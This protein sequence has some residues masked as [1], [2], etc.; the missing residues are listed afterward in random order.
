MLNA[1]VVRKDRGQVLVVFALVLPILIL[2]AG[3]AIDAGVLYVTKAKLSAAVDAAT[4]TG[5]K[6][7]TQGQATASTLALDMFDANYGANPPTPTITFPTDQYGDQQVEV[8][9]TANVNTYFMRYLPQWK[10]VAVGDTAIATR[11]KLDMAIVLDRSGS[12]CGG[13]VSCTYNGSDFGPGDDGWEALQ[14][15]VPQFV[16]LFDN[17]SDEVSL[18]SFSSNAVI[19]FPI[20]TGFQTPITNDINGMLVYGGTFGT[21]NGGSWSTLNSTTQTIGPP[22]SLADMEINQVTAQPG[23]NLIRV[24]VYFTDGLM[25]ASQDYFHCGGKANNTLSLINYGGTDS[26]TGVFFFDPTSATNQFGSCNDGCSTGFPY[27]SK[28]D[29]CTDANGNAVETFLSQQTGKQTAFTRA[30][31]TAETQYRAIQTAI[32]MRTESPLPIYIYTV[33]LGSSV[34]ATTQAFLAQL[35]NDPSYPSTFINTQPAGEFFYINDCPSTPT[36]ICTNSVR[37]VFN[38][39]AAKVLLRLTE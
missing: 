11:G 20:A 25:N 14:A 36:S 30:N 18:I 37:Q 33:G 23:Q 7:L 28:A 35:A 6:T 26:G 13:T 8:T 3:L 32:A 2:F 9:A 24:M 39:I 15:A 10:T 31:V 21:G 19:N 1:T 29:A 38:T 16:D 34:S 4:L 22:L 5:M 12:M 27:D 17:S